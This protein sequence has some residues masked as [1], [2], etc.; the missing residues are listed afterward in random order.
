[1]R[2]GRNYAVGVRR[3]QQDLAL[4]ATAGMWLLGKPLLRLLF[5]GNAFDTAATQMVRRLAA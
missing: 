2:I 1:M 3:D 5:E 4:P